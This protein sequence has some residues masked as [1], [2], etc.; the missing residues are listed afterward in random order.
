MDPLDSPCIGVCT[1]APETALCR[2]CWRTIEEIANWRTL[3]RSA[4][5]RVL[6]A[7]EA[8]RPPAAPRG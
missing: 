3:D 6:A 7:C 4:R 5:A 8:R 2:G 1:I